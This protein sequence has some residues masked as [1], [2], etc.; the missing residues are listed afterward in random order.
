MN[1]IL[2]PVDG[3]VHALKAAHIAC[4]FA[5]KYDGRISL[6]YVLPKSIQAEKLLSLMVAKSFGPKLKSILTAQAKMK[7]G[8]ASHA[9]KVAAGEKILSQAAAKIRHQ[10]IDATKLPIGE[11]DVVEIILDAINA[12]QAN[13][14]VLGSRGASDTHSSSFG[15]VSHAVFERAECTCLAVK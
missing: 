11:G 13:V 8:E 5:Q 10:G 4:D 2:V 14:V 9:V 15:S 1:S 6:L 3:S 12:T 7:N